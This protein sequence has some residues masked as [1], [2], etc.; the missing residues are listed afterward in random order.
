MASDASASAT[1]E[2]EELAE[3]MDELG[4][5]EEEIDDLV[6]EEKVPDDSPYPRWPAIGKGHT[7][8]EYGD[9]KFYKN[10]RSAW[11]LAQ[12]VKFRSLGNNLYTMQFSCLGDW[13]KVME[14]GPWAFRGQPVLLAPYD[15]F[16]KPSSIDLKS[17][18]IW[19][20]IHGSKFM[21]CLM[22]M[23]S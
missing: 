19:V 15:G 7:T 21:I 5:V 18:K 12:S 10:M 8:K 16:S 13:M 17:F 20:Q 4:I 9:H 11:D 23:R 1:K 14:G 3:L 22:D 2:E 6:Y